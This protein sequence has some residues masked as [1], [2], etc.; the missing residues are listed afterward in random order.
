M[1]TVSLLLKRIL[2]N[3][4]MFILTVC[5]TAII[6]A[7]VLGV[8]NANVISHACEAAVQGENRMIYRSFSPDVED[9]FS[10]KQIADIMSECKDY[11]GT[12]FVADSFTYLGENASLEIARK[13]LAGEYIPDELFK[14]SKYEDIVAT[15]FYNEIT[16]K[17]IKYPLKNGNWDDIYSEKNGAVPC[18]V[19]GKNSSEYRVGDVIS[20]FTFNSDGN[21][22]VSVNYYVAGILKDPL[23]LLSANVGST[24]VQRAMKISETFDVGI[25]EPLVIVTNSSLSEKYDIEKLHIRKNYFVFF[26]GKTTDEQME[27]YAVMLGD[28]CAAVDKDMII[29]EELEITI[30]AEVSLPIVFLLLI[31]SLCSIISVSVISFI[32]SLDEYKIYCI[33]GC[34][35]RKM[36][37][38]NVLYCA[39][40][41]AVS[42]IIS[43]GLTRLLSMLVFDRFR[44]YF[45]NSFE[46]SAMLSA[47][48]AIT[49]FVS[50]LIPFLLQKKKSIKELLLETTN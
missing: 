49:A 3:P 34:T 12:S 32:N 29:S 5:Q 45:V 21:E 1:K 33:F 50:I 38:I 26:D 37:L 23:F 30:G 15:Y 27:K 13:N 22:I 43:A 41:L 25:S 20:G 4:F 19:G 36:L 6:S 14:R 24:D 42:G 44:P 8:Y 48:F 2:N 9:E 18:F 35:A 7:A 11:L 40:Y 10:E 47:A 16:L 31:I 17:S 39:C 46:V 28:T